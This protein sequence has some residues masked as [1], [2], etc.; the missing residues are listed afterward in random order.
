MEDSKADSN[1]KPERESGKGGE[2]TE[3]KGLKGPENYLILWSSCLRVV[4]EGAF[5]LTPN[6]AFPFLSQ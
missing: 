1:A 4:V 6:L 5:P 3:A 2:Y